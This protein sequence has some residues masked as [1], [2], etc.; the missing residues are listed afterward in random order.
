MSIL[1]KFGTIIDREFVMHPGK[2]KF[3]WFTSLYIHKT[4]LLTALKHDKISLSNHNPFHPTWWIFFSKLHNK[5]WEN[6]ITWLIL[7]QFSTSQKY[8]CFLILTPPMSEKERW[9]RRHFINNLKRIYCIRPILK[10]KGV[11]RKEFENKFASIMRS[12]GD[13]H[14]IFLNIRGLTAQANNKSKEQNWITRL[15]EPI[16]L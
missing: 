14:Q 6:F 8:P 13:I 1:V 15:V 2:S 3:S 5:I 4:P 12:W 7:R 16:F 10:R 9:I 11:F